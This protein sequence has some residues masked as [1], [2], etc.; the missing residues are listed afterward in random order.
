VYEILGIVAE[1]G[2]TPQDSGPEL[3]HLEQRLDRLEQLMVL[4]AHQVGIP[5]Q[6]IAQLLGGS[7]LPPS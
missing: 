5:P 6:A 3:Q 1:L 2:D 4:I 7:T